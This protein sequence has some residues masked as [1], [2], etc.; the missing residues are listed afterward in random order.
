M[1][2]VKPKI[3][4]LSSFSNPFIT[5]RTVIRIPTPNINPII[6]IFDIM[7]INDRLYFEN[8]KRYAMSKFIATLYQIS[9]I[10]WKS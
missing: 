1:C 9:A 5:E 4:S 6:D 10:I 2:D 8:K 7:D 3:L